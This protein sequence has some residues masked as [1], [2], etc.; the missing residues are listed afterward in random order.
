MNNKDV[1]L[2]KD[3]DG[4]MFLMPSFWLEANEYRKVTSE[5]NQLYKSRYKGKQIATHV[6]FGIDGRPYVYWFE[7]HGFNNYNIY[8]RVI[9]NH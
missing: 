2:P 9:D 1:L 4:K 3:A 8:M 5:I 7:N 6:S